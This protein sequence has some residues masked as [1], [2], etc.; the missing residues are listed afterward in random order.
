MLTTR[1][2]TLLGNWTLGH[3]FTVLS[4]LVALSILAAQYTIGHLRIDTDTAKLIAPDAPFQHYRQLY[5][6]SFS[7]D[8]S[9]LLLVVL[10]PFTE[11]EIEPVS[12]PET[13]GRS[14][15]APGVEVSR[16]G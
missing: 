13:A 1:A 5:E 10:V 7:Q 4:M 16:W 14:A 6:Q 8:L 15:L 12:L 2:Y 11:G 3:P 9:T